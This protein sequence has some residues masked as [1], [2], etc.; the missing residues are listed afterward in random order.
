[1]DIG[2]TGFWPWF[3]Q[4]ITAVY[5]VFGLTV[6]LIVGHMR[7]HLAFHGINARLQAGAWVAFDLT[8]LAAALYH[9]MNGLWAIG[10]DLSPKR[11]ARLMLSYGVAAVGLVFFVYGIFALAA[12]A[13]RSQ[14][15]GMG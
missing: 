12:L 5:L 6:H 15:G 1:M 3:W 11:R 9:G 13:Q 4:R 7:G 14:I 10:L 2:K 8:L